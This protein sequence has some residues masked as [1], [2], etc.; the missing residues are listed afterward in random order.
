MSPA[1]RE[2]GLMT[3]RQEGAALRSAR[4][5]QFVA[6]SLS[7]V[8]RQQGLS[9]DETRA[10]DIACLMTVLVTRGA[11]PRSY[12]APYMAPLGGLSPAYAPCIGAPGMP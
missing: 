12:S 1:R 7:A 2:P 5:V 10:W 11:G 9:L 8:C 6:D 3:K 4:T